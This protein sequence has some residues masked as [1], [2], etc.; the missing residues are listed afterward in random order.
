MRNA[1]IRKKRLAVERKLEDFLRMPP[2]IIMGAAI[3][4]ISVGHWGS[5]RGPL[6][7]TPGVGPQA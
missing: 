5:S 6:V 4:G 1:V 3:N 2:R 7:P